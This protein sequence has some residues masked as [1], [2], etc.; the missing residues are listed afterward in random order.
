V[1]PDVLLIDEALSVGD[2]HFRGKCLNRLND[3]R[4]KGGT[5]VFVSH[6][7]GSIKTMCQH[8]ILIDKGEVVEQGTPEKVSDEYLK[9]VKARGNEQKMSMLHRGTAD[10]P[11]WG[12]GEIEVEEVQLLGGDGKSSLVFETG[13][14]FV[15]RM[16]YKVHEDCNDPVFG[17][18]LYRSDG[19]YVNGSNHH[20][21]HQ[22]IEM[23]EVK[24]GETGEVDMAMGELP[25][26]EGQYYLTTFLYDHSKASPTAID[27][28]EHVA[29]FQILDPDHH[30]HGILKLPTAWAIRRSLPNEDE[31]TNLESG[32]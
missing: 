29:T 25:L 23:G 32:S 28:R 18:G 4:D 11:R 10:Y 24:A 31:V 6:D 13:E 5:T 3:F 22:H 8:V 30:Q 15:I 9:R 26:L 17:I 27:H 7:M 19:T 1:N 14:L 16:I 20:W 2:E 21:R 12:T